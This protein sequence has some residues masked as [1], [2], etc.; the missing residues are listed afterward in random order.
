WVV[1]SAYYETPIGT[2]PDIILDDGT[3]LTKFTSKNASLYLNQ[4]KASGIIMPQA[5]IPDDGDSTTS[6]QL[7]YIVATYRNPGGHSPPGQQNQLNH[8]QFHCM[9]R[10]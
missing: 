3:K 1:A 10:M 8:L 2:S 6:Q 9:V 7:V 4:T 5:L